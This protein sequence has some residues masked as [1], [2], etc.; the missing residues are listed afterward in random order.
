M[1]ETED[2]EADEQLKHNRHQVAESRINPCAA[3]KMWRECVV[4]EP[5]IRP[6][7]ERLSRFVF[8]GRASGCSRCRQSGS[9]LRCRTLFWCVHSSI[10][11]SLPVESYDG[12]SLPP[13]YWTK[14]TS[15]A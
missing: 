4:L 13:S 10:F 1:D 8:C 15:S 5:A 7:Q 11:P 2:R 3:Q 12:K 6:H 9:F 14:Y